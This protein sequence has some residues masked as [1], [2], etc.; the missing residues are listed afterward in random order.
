M[1]IVYGWLKPLL[2]KIIS[3]RDELKDKTDIMD[4]LDRNKS[5][6]NKD[7]K[8]LFN[9][10]FNESTKPPTTHTPTHSSKK[11]SGGKKRSRQSK[12]RTKRRRRN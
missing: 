1:N 4:L 8:K 9:Q 3:V 7:E 6:L 12:P 11:I 10:I 2:N 5:E